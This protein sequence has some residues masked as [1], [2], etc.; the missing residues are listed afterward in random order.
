[1]STALQTPPAPTRHTVVRA[2]RT[3][4]VA[5]NSARS[6]L[7]AWRIEA[8]RLDDALL[9]VS[10]LLTNAFIHGAD[11]VALSLRHCGGHLTVA[12]RDGGATIRQQ[13][14]ADVLDEHGR[15]LAIVE[16]LAHHCGVH[17]T[18]GRTVVWARL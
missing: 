6:I 12:V 1:M 15:G 16:A 5:R 3:V 2:P 14:D 17:V 13:P 18:A 11:P 10:E 9:I 7:S 8:A 4:A